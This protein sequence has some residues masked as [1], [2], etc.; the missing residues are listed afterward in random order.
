MNAGSLLRQVLQTRLVK[1]LTNV[2]E[3]MKRCLFTDLPKARGWLLQEVLVL[4]F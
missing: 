3:F 2:A 1:A 4:G